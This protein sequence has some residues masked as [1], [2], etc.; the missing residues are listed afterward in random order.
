M[1]TK[2]LKIAAKLVKE[3]WRSGISKLMYWN[4]ILF[5]IEKRFASNKVFLNS[6]LVAGVYFQP[7]EESSMM[8]VTARFYTKQAD[9]PETESMKYNQTSLTSTGRDKH[10]Y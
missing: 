7:V 8:T 4:Y 1:Q 9:V 3:L 2:N 6:N 5:K 10:S